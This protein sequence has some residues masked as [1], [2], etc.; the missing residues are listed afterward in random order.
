MLAWGR[1]RHTSARK[2]GLG[3]GTGINREGT[4]H[5]CTAEQWRP[6]SVSPGGLYMAH[7][8]SPYSGSSHLP[9]SLDAQQVP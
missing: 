7:S 2:P 6:I 5:F 1:A 3:S 9:V 4:R 8:M